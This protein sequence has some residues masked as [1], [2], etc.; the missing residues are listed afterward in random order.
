MIKLER[1]RERLVTM[2][3]ALLIA[4][5]WGGAAGLLYLQIPHPI[6]S[7]WKRM[8]SRYLQVIGATV[9]RLD[10]ELAAEPRPFGVILGLSTVRRGIDPRVLG[11]GAG[12]DW[13]NLAVGGGTFSQL[14]YYSAPLLGSGLHPAVAVLGVHS[15]WLA[16]SDSPAATRVVPVRFPL[17]KAALD[18]PELKRLVKRRLERR[19]AAR[20]GPAARVLSP[21]A[22]ALSGRQRWLSMHLNGARL[23]FKHAVAQARLQLLP[24]FGV[25]LRI[26]YPQPGRDPWETPKAFDRPSAKEGN[27]ARLAELWRQLGWFTASAYRSSNHEV[28]QLRALVA[29]LKRRGATVVVALM[30]EPP[31]YRHRF[32]IEARI[33]LL[34]TLGSIPDI[35]IIDHWGALDD[36]GLF[37]DRMHLNESGRAAYSSLLAKRLAP[38]VAAL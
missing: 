8:D 4:L 15:V 19:E 20:R 38:I 3:A 1:Y 16:E 24:T 32:P 9:A 17:P 27:L 37:F 6:R 21:L 14:A 36:D 13:I 5:L 18:T 26:I 28:A 29:A 2:L 10:A 11:Q 22:A 23:G 30:P 35:E 33:L 25:D 12:L 31:N 34:E 7:V